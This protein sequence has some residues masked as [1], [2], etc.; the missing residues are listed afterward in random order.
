MR[1]SQYQQGKESTGYATEYICTFARADYKTHSRIL[2]YLLVAGN[3]NIAE[4]SWERT[5][6]VPK[7]TIYHYYSEM[8]VQ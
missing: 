8:K 6:K 3:F 5:E 4:G 2:I 1:K 7:K